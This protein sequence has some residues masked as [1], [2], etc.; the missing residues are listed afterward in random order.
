MAGTFTTKLLSDG[1]LPSSTGVLYT[2][3]SL[4]SAIIKNISLVNNHTDSVN[5][6]LYVKTAGGT[7]RKLIPKDMIFATRYSL[8]TDE[9]YTLEAGDIVEGDASVGSVVDYTIHGVQET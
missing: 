5:I 3:P 9:V 4:T 6:N 7:L 8:E 1:Q 2:V